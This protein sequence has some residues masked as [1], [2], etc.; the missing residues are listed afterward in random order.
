[1]CSYVHLYLEKNKDDEPIYKAFK[2][3]NSS[4]LYLKPVLDNDCC[5]ANQCTNS[6][7]FWHNRLCHLNPKHMT[8]MK[9]YIDNINNF[10]CDTCDI[11]KIIRKP[12]PNVDIDLNS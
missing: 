7:K 9:E 12:H 11:T 5:F 2:N 8:N 3:N 6:Y 1:M 4:E 10:R